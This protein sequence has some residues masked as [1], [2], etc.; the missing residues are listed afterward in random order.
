MRPGL[1][2]RPLRY[3]EPVAAFGHANLTAAAEV[4]ASGR[5]WRIEKPT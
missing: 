5:W 3:R 4:M 2:A 1:F